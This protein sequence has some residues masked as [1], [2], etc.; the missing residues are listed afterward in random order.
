MAPATMLERLKSLYSKHQGSSISKGEKKS[1]DKRLTRPADEP[2]LSVQT[3]AI[4]SV[5][6]PIYPFLLHSYI[7]LSNIGS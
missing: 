7:Y 3:V 2:S 1:K 6:L 4:L 5:I